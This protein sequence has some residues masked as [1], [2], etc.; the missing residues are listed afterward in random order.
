MILIPGQLVYSTGPPLRI[1]GFQNA[2]R[3]S[4]TWV[5]EGSR[6]SPVDGRRGPLKGPRGPL[7]G[8][9]GP[10]K[11]PRG[12]FEGPRSPF[13]GPRGPYSRL[14]G[15]TRALSSEGLVFPATVTVSEPH[16]CTPT[17]RVLR[18]TRFKNH[19]SISGSFKRTPGSFKR[20]P[21]S[22]KRTPGSFKRTPWSF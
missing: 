14:S 17:G 6:R 16:R 10:L 1:P 3:D 11:G 13:K 19:L 12:P 4:Y 15:G 2:A 21:G 7:K 5:P 22:F 18:I 9:W 8:P 20:T